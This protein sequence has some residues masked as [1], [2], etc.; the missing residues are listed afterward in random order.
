MRTILVF[1]FTVYKN[2]WKQNKFQRQKYKKVTFLN[3]K[4]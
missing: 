4:K 2:D 1:F 3:T